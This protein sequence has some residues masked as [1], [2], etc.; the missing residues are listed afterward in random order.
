MSAVAIDVGVIEERD[1][2]FDSGPD[3]GSDLRI[4]KGFDAHQPENDIRNFDSRIVQSQCLHPPSL[5]L[6]GRTRSAVRR[7]MR[8]KVQD[9]GLGA[10]LEA[11]LRQQ[12]RNVVL[13]G[14]L[15]EGE[16]QPDLTVGE[17]GGDQREDLG[18]ARGE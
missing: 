15:G 7:R 16:F 5:R 6:R 2:G 9:R 3:E 17:T 14:L 13:D 10:T 8:P 11:E 4:G 18:L 12:A 1:P